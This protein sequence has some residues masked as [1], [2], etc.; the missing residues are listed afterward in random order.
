MDDGAF[1]R[2]LRSSRE[3]PDSWESFQVGTKFT[4][5]V[6]T[7]ILAGSGVVI[8]RASDLEQ[9]LGATEVLWGDNTDT[10]LAWAQGADRSMGMTQ[11]N[12]LQNANRFNAMF[13][14]IG[15]GQDVVM[16]MSQDSRSYQPTCP[17]CGAGRRTKPLTR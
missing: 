12:A 9:T 4:A 15:H 16:D 3:K 8:K 6:T 1:Q 2:G 11:N 5:G 13:K 10:M 14:T 17:L 7:P